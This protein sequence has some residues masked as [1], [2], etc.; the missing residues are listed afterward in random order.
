MRLALT[1]LIRGHL[2]DKQRLIVTLCTLLSLGF[3]TTAWV[4]Y[5][6]SKS[7]IR[8][9]IVANELP[10]TADNLYSEIQ[11]DL[12]RPVVISSMMAS[13]TFLRDWVLA[14]EQEPDRIT[15]YLREVRDRYAAITSFFISDRTRIY[16][17]AEG[18]LKNIRENDPRDVWYFR[19]RSMSAP[20]EINVDPDLANKDATT[21]FINY[22]VLDY[23]KRYIGVTGIGITMD[24]ART[25]LNSYQERYGRSIYFVDRTGKVAL[26]GK[27]NQVQAAD[28]H[29]VKGLNA[30]ADTILRRGS[31]S[32]QYSAGRSERLLNVRLIPELNWFLFVEGTA[33]AAMVEIRRTLYVNLAICLIITAIVLLATSITINRYQSRLE[34]MATTDKL[35][36]L[37]NRQAFDVLMPQV[38]SETRRHGNPLCAVLID[39]DHFKDV[40]DRHGHL[41]G[42]KVLRTVAGVIK[43][44][45]RASDI[46][47]RWGGEEFLVVLKN[48]NLE[49][50]GQLAEKIRSAIEQTVT[51]QKDRTIMVTASL[52]VAAYE[53]GDTPDRLLAR[54]DKALYRAKEQ[55]RNRVHKA[56]PASTDPARLPPL[57]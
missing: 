20:Y 57:A 50:A 35:T 54:A 55:G 9:S 47:S 18:I 41:A 15:R 4:N 19:V 36:G 6:V 30:I 23:N 40:N 3:A 38:M 56:D 44:R 37:A 34:E 28:I 8:N 11:K 29:E 46:I 24:A 45:L 53:Q 48:I 42:D 31:G 27:D 26:V 7:A 22:R 21:I 16:Y 51:A 49:Q 33:D 10:L 5:E 17:Q 13:D 25:L 52:G 39:I 43:S 2:G 14:G 12:I 1:R 32:Y